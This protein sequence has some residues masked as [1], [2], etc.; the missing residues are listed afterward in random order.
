MRDSLRTIRVPLIRNRRLLFQR[1]FSSSESFSGR[2]F[3]QAGKVIIAVCFK[4]KYR[5][6]DKKPLE[7][8]LGS[9]RPKERKFRQSWQSGKNNLPIFILNIN[10]T[11]SLVR[12]KQFDAGLKSCSPTIQGRCKNCP[13][14]FV[15]PDTLKYDKEIF[16]SLLL[17]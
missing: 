7:S 13:K 3:L 6:S 17:R 2:L 12:G 11:R 14:C 16:V 8:W 1:R 5:A 4:T 10:N 9:D 15:F